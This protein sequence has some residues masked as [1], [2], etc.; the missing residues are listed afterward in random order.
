MCTEGVLVKV[1]ILINDWDGVGVVDVIF[2]WFVVVV[3]VIL[4]L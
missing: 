4:T 3:D 1:L 2:V